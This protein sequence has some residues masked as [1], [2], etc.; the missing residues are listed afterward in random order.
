MRPTITVESTEMPFACE[1]YD[2]SPDIFD[3]SAHCMIAVI[4][5]IRLN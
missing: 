3:G 4:L 2:L 1:I 5:Q